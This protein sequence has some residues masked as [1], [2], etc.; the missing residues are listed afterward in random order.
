MQSNAR[1]A[2]KTKRSL[3]RFCADG[4]LRRRIDGWRQRFVI[5]LYCP[6]RGTSLLVR[7]SLK[8]VVLN[9]EFLWSLHCMVGTVAIALRA[10]RFRW[11]WRS[12]Q[13]CWRR[14]SERVCGR[15]CGRSLRDKQ[16]LAGRLRRKVVVKLMEYMLYVSLWH[17]WTRTQI[18]WRNVGWLRRR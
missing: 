14:L 2:D 9:A 16:S 1:R 11:T 8:L 3:G 6:E 10:E 17:E 13:S 18:A 4:A 5:L 15:W 12:I 7:S